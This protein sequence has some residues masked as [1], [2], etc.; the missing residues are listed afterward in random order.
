MIHEILSPKR[1]TDT[2]CTIEDIL[3]LDVIPISHNYPD[4][5]DLKSLKHWKNVDYILWILPKA[6]NKIFM[7]YS[8]KNFIELSWLEICH[9]ETKNGN[10]YNITSTPAMHC[11]MDLF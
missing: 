11:L 5:L 2:P 9:L 1:V 7:K 3:Q 6:M 4:H 10:V 8:V